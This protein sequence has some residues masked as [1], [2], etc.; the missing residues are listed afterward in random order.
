MNLH[1]IVTGA[2]LVYIC[3]D[4]RKSFSFEWTYYKKVPLPAP[5]L[6]PDFSPH[7]SHCLGAL[8]LSV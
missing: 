6:A 5:G 1:G 2:V 8:M 3:D 4:F 7:F